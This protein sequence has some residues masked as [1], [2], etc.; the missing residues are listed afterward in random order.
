M[1]NFGG[2]PKLRV[3]DLSSNHL[4]ILPTGV[5][6]YLRSL[7]SL[8]LSNNT[9][10]DLSTNVLRGLSSLRVLRLD[11]NSIPIEQIN[12]LFSDVSQL[13]ELYLNHCNLSSV[14][15]LALD[16]IPQLRQLGIGGN[17]LRMVPTKEL[18]AVPQLTVLDLS[19]NAIQEVNACAFCANNITKLDLSH[20][21]LGV[22]EDSPFDVDA[23]RNI[24]LRHL[25]LSYNHMDDFNSKWLGWAQDELISIALSGNVIKREF[26]RGRV[27]QV[28]VMF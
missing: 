3:L 21:L 26:I 15:K 25:D 14:S 16:Q 22:S 4:N 18:Q 10:T 28:F 5:F 23:F 17:G 9:I 11:W 6:T 12:D 20:N 27:H 7:R 19:N 2:M 1:S 24:P 8:T 13:D